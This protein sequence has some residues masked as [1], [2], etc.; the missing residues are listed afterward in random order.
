MKRTKLSEQ[1]L[2][3]AIYGS[4]ALSC[5][6][7]IAII[8]YIVFK[9]APSIDW[10]F[11]SSPYKGSQ[12]GIYPMIV[13][14]LYMIG[15]SLAVAAPIGVC[16]AIYLN[17]YAKDGKL[18]RLIRFA[19]DS[20]SGIP[21]IIYGLFGYMFFVTVLQLKMSI[22]SG[23]LTLA[24]MVLPLVIRTT[25]EALKTVPA[26]YREGSLALG[27][28]KITT[29]LRIVLPSAAEGIITSI[30]LS[31]G[32]IVGETAAVYLTAGMVTRVPGGILDSGRTLAVHLYVLAKEGISFER[33]Y[34]SATVL[35]VIIA[36]LNLLANRLATGMRKK[37]T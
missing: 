22:L 3:L 11:L 29:I 35:L 36:G 37:T 26:G 27:A 8:G 9:G 20:L 16:S 34:A 19:T 28:S 32:R 12:H 4:A 1:L 18:V 25:E 2:Y 21:S 14:T 5:T 33:A 23:A 13:T 15:L 31:I 24:I 10:T 7:M 6:A 17:E 30:I